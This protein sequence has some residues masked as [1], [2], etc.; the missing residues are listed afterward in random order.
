MFGWEAGGGVR[1]SVVGTMTR[2]VTIDLYAGERF[3][4]VRC[5]PGFVA[6][7]LRCDVSEWTDREFPLAECAPKVWKS[8]S[9]ILDSRDSMAAAKRLER[10]LLREASQLGPRSV[11]QEIATR[12]LESGGSES[13]LASAIH[14]GYSARQLQRMFVREIGIPPKLFARIARFRRAQQLALAYPRWS[15]SELAQGAGYFDQSHWIRERRAL[16]PDPA[17]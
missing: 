4:A 7:W 13:V 16:D 6:R 12:I 8:L 2:S 3:V 11:A 15:G 9:P 5:L 10:C 14:A 17:E 1:A